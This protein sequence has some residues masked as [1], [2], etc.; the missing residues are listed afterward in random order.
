[1]MTNADIDQIYAQFLGM[2]HTAALKAIYTLGY[3]N[4]AG[5]AIDDNLTDKAKVATKPTPA[6][7]TSM[8]NNP[9]LKKP[10]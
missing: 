6:Q 8:T 5:T 2:G 1:M 9:K 10:D 7:M 3:A 4:G